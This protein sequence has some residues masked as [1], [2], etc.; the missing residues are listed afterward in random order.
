MAYQWKTGMLQKSEAGDLVGFLGKA[1]LKQG[2]KEKGMSNCE[3][4][5]WKI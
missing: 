4:L 1:S 5:G 3:G 2:F